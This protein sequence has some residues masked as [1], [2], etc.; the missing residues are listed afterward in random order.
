MER[1]LIRF[2]R[3]TQYSSLIAHH[4]SL[5]TH[6]SV[7]ITHHSV[8]ITHYSSLITQYS[9]LITQ[10]SSL[11]FYHSYHGIRDLRRTSHCKQFHPSAGCFTADDD[12][13]A[14]VPLV[15]NVPAQLI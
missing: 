5:S 1:R 2:A 11:L 9:V 7:L 14:V 10:Y 8:L 12:N 13:R 4:S 3:C 15:F 6:H